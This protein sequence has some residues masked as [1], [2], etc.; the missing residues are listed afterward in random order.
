MTKFRIYWRE[1]V[2]QNWYLDVEAKNVEEAEN[3][4]HEGNHITGDEVLE[5]TDYIESEFEGVEKL[6][7]EDENQLELF[8]DK[9]DATGEEH[10]FEDADNN[11]IYGDEVCKW[12]GKRQSK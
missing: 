6:K 3:V 2:V 10:D 7:E 4:F 1:E 8:D 5:D 11:G 12:C 9:C